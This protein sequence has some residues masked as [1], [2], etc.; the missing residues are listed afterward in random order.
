VEFELLDAR[1]NILGRFTT[2]RDGVITFNRN[3]A[4]GRY[5]IRE[6]RAAEGY[7][8]DE[9]MHAVV[10]LPDATVELVVENRLM[11]GNIRIEKRA[12]EAN[13]ITGDRAGAVLADAVF[14]ITNEQYEVVDTIT[15]DNRGVATSRDLPLGRYAIR[16]ITSPDFYLLYDGVFYADI[17]GHGDI[18]RFEVLNHPVD[19]EVTIEKTGNVEALAGDVIRYDFNNITNSSNIPLDDF[20]W[21]DILPEEVRLERIVTGTWNERL[22]YRVVFATNRNS[23]YRVWRADMLTTSN[24]ELSVSDLNLAENEFVTSFRF[25]FGTVPTGFREVEAPHIFARVL[26]DLPHE[27]RIVNRVEVGGRVGDEYV[28]DTDSWVT[29]VFAFPRG[30]LPETGLQ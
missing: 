29:I 1:N 27:H 7:L 5:Q 28:Y 18:I 26:E 13:Q 30:P 21:R 10:I 3:L 2:D 16:E 15:T 14:E 25:E 23:S 11:T 12:A 22:R 4:P 6:V 19:V 20:F 24:H 9:R 17:R 8:L